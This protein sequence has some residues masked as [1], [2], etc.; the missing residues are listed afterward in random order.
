MASTKII[1]VGLTALLA[2]GGASAAVSGVGPQALP[3][4][5]TESTVENVNAHAVAD[6][7]TVTVTVTDRGEPIEGVSISTDSDDEERVNS[8]DANGTVTF[9]IEPSEEL[10]LELDGEQF[11]GE[12]EYTV[13]DGSLVLL[14]E[15]YEYDRE[16]T[17]EVRELNAHAVADNETVTVT[18]TDSGELVEG[19]SVFADSDDEE[20]DGSTDANGT[21]AFDMEPSE[22]LEFELEG[23]EFEGELEYTVEDGSLVLLE[24]EYERDDVD[25]EEDEKDDEDEKDE[26]REDDEEEDDFD[27]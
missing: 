26:E 13:E 15:E 7:G 4:D 21:V 27:D 1:A 19:V 2:V 24:E 3:G 6:N 22:E 10:E 18:V 11:D 8:T 20:M 23:E 16:D 9:D 12:L 25:D 17:D 5:A 14:E